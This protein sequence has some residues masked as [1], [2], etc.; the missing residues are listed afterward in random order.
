MWD[1]FRAACLMVVLPAACALAEAVD[2]ADQLVVNKAKRELLLLR[3]GNVIRSCKI[4]LGRNPAGPKR[5]QGDGK[6]PEGTYTISGRN[7]ASA[8]HRSLR[9]SYPNPA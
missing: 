5:R 3:K 8:F 1:V 9:I 4:A 7:P 6:T 2:Q